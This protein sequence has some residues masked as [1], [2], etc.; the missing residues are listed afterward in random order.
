MKSISTKIN[1]IVAALQARGIDVS[2][3]QPR[4]YEFFDNQPYAQAGQATTKFFSREVGSRSADDCNLD[5]PSRFPTNQIFVCCALSTL[6]IPGADQNST[7]ANAQPAFIDDFLVVNNA[8]R[9]EF[10]VGSTSTYVNNGPL[11]SFPAARQI[12]LGGA[13][14]DSSTAGAAQRTEIQAANIS[15]D[16]YEITPKIIMPGEQFRFDVKFASNVPVSV[17]GRMEARMYGFLA[18]S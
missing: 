16:I 18:E 9:V 1:S 11:R 5:A 17:A 12:V 3:F 6:F 7:G 4:Y 13:V 10:A 15:G 8:G 14:T 2:K